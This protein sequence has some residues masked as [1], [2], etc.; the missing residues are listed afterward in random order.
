MLGEVN[1][2]GIIQLTEGTTVLQAVIQAGYFTAKAAPSTVWVYKGG[3]DGKV[4]KVNL[5]GAIS[6]GRVDNNIIL[7]SGD[8]V[9]V[10][11]DPFKSALEWIPVINNLITFYNNVSGLF[12]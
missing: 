9:F 1:K 6:G 4:E 2:P 11:S 8:I 12:K 10:P 3:V 7:E 5:S